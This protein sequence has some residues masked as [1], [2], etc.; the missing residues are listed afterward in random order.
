MY[1]ILYVEDHLAQRDIMVQLLELS[2]YEVES[3][4]DG[5]DGVELAHSWNPD[6][7]LMDLRMPRMDGFEAIEVLRSDPTTAEIPIIAIS[8]W[9]SAKH[10]ERA[11]DAGADEHFTKPVDLSQLLQ[12]VNRYL[13]AD[14]E[15]LKRRRAEMQD[16]LASMQTSP[17]SAEEPGIPQTRQSKVLARLF[18]WLARVGL[19]SS[20]ISEMQ[21]SEVL[22]R[23][24]AA[25]KHDLVGL[26]GI[27][28]QDVEAMF[29]SPPTPDRLRR[30]WRSARHAILLLQN[31]ADLRPGGALNQEAVNLASL[32]EEALDLI[33]PEFKGRVT[34]TRHYGREL[35]GVRV[36]PL[37]FEQVAVNLFKNA[38]EAK[39]NTLHVVLEKVDSGL[40]L[41]VTD[42]GEGVAQPH[43][44]HLF[45][46]WHTTRIGE[47][48]GLGLYIVKTILDRH[49]WGIR[50]ES[51]PGRG[52][53]F[54]ITIP[55][56]SLTAPVTTRRALH[57]RE[58]QISA[59]PR[60]L[61]TDDNAD[62]L[63]FTFR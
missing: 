55:P 48:R 13:S 3:A 54:F 23:A 62:T 18:G 1:H 53:S 51:R 9:A 40:C 61:I 26:L 12:T 14:R 36:D 8:A 63:D 10:K 15:D 32:I 28:Q 38:K 22:G 2:G 34:V 30:V 37:R 44:K 59:K 21:Q 45:D 25:T 6:I 35:P 46:L 58:P 19:Y 20:G 29:N 47:G 39:A 41:E 5:V 57:E 49:G 4:D 52:T 43:H 27:I 17:T 60:V 56:D 33:E 31:V 16:Q 7:I 50:V 11:I 24:F 42:N